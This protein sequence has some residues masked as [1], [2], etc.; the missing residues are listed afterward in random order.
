MMKPQF[1]CSGAAL[2]VALA[3]GAASLS[4]AWAQSPAPAADAAA[5]N[6]ADVKLTLLAA[7]GLELTNAFTGRFDCGAV[8]PIA[9]PRIERAFILRND[10]KLPLSITRL[11]TSCG[12]ESAAFLRDGREQPH[13]EQK[14]AILLPGEQAE[15]RL[16]VSLS[17]QQGYAKHAF[18]W[19]Y[20]KES[21]EA[22]A[23]VEIVAQI[24]PS[25]IFEPPLLR[26][27]S[28]VAG[29]KQTISFSAAF[30]PRLLTP[31]QTIAVTGSSVF[32]QVEAEKSEQLEKRGEKTFRVRSF[33]ATLLPAAPSGR[34]SGSVSFG[35]TEPAPK[36]GASP[37]PLTVSIP[38]VGERGGT[39]AAS[40]TLL[41]FG[42]LTSGQEIKRVLLLTAA[43]PKTLQAAKITSDSRLLTIRA[44]PPEAAGS[45][46][47]Q[48][49][50]ITLSG[51]TP[52]GPFSARVTIETASGE[53]L[54]IPV[55]AQIEK[56][57][58][59]PRAPK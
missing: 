51:Q 19:V 27:S 36:P 48:R 5:S 54:V 41:M 12:C 46:A 35:L 16:A 26:F 10:G 15:I 7:S 13:P 28:A 47:A 34:I 33:H 43:A 3:S 21:T 22:L 6:K 44:A 53:K 24:E 17:G 52:P 29:S 45:G 59:A 38:F 1:T 18:L 55:I 49:L 20:G 2:L 14:T 58:S 56:D 11:K 4:P 32:I 23:S 37:T 39:F 42:S 8:D 25:V 9:T 50:E 40:P 30:D 31:G 57:A